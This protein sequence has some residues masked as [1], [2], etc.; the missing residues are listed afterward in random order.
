MLGAV[1][2][3]LAS[4]TRLAVDVTAVDAVMISVV[5][6][7]VTSLWAK[8]Y[9]WRELWGMYTAWVEATRATRLSDL[10]SPVNPKGKR[11]LG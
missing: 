10:V 9:E 2:V 4:A 11:I 1:F 3:V 6:S 5:T 8:E 7:V